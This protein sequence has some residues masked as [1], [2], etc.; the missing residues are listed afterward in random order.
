MAAATAAFLAFVDDAAEPSPEQPSVPGGAARTRAPSSAV[1]DRR[2]ASMRVRVAIRPVDGS[3]RRNRLP[4]ALGSRPIHVCGWPH[5]GRTVAASFAACIAAGAAST[6]NTAGAAIAA[7]T[8]ASSGG[9]ASSIVGEDA[10][11]DNSCSGVVVVAGST[12]P[13]LPKLP[14]WPH[15]PFKEAAGFTEADQLNSAGVTA[16]WARAHP[17]AG[18]AKFRQ[19][20]MLRV[21]GVASRAACA[22]LATHLDDC[23][24]EA[25]V[26]SD[27][28]RGATGGHTFGKIYADG[29]SNGSAVPVGTRNRWDMFLEPAAPAVARVLGEVV[30]GLGSLLADLVTEE[31]KVCELASLI[32]DRSALVHGSLS[33]WSRSDSCGL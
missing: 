19:Q 25:V 7:G 29:S 18:A 10:G 27:A 8:A 31:A 12:A 30:E 14:L 26:A 22:E 9:D 23:L 2:L 4:P 16:A 17:E 20:G 1:I 5:H 24:L 33:S 13:P 15:P 6:A 21:R 28:L 11:H 3:D 32:S